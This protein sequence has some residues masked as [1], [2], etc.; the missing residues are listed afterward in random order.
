MC[1]FT[2]V[3]TQVIF[4]TICDVPLTDAHYTELLLLLST[5][6]IKSFITETFLLL[7]LGHRSLERAVVVEVT[8]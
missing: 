3:S 8:F 6:T 7:V 2:G 4:I 1:P 5:V